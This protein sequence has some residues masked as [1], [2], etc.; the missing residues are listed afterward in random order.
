[1]IRIGL[2]G[3]GTMGEW[4]AECLSEHE[5]SGLVAICDIE[6]GRARELARTWSVKNSYG[7]CAE[8]LSAERLDAVAVATPD[9]HH[10]EP[11]VAALVSGAHVLVE[12]PLATTLEDGLAIREAVGRSGREF[13]VNFGN[14]HRPRAKMLRR[15]LVEDREVGE[16][17]NV[18]V[19]LNE[20]ISKTRELAWAAE[21]SPTWFLLSH[22]V[23]YVRYVTGLEIV[24]IF[25]YETAKVLRERKLETSDTAV[26]VGRLDNGGRVFLG[27]S[28]IYPEDYGPDID[29]SIR[30]LG[31]DGLLECQM[32]PHDMT[33][34][35]RT[36][37]AVNYTYPNRDH[38]GKRDNW[39]YQSTKHFVHCL[40]KGL[41]PTPDVEDGLRCL[42]VLLAMDETVR[43]G[44]PVGIS[45]QD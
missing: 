21:T 43:T 18:Y 30:I 27:S 42:R 12:K 40:E 31:S 33:I 15:L 5:G 41:H 14:R 9:R 24:E 1:M 7:S 32:H 44:N 3:A 10:R 38:A 39:W 20:R 34:H 8:M 25:G 16:V 17:G 22:C 2:V 29:F 37:K 26:F 45:Y 19:E 11:V 6:P 13:M 23:D 28:W 4:Y 36:S 35:K